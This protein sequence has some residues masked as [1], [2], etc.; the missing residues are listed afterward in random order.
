M[1][2][3]AQGVGVRLSPL[4]DEIPSF[5]AVHNILFPSPAPFWGAAKAPYPTNIWWTNLAF[6]SFPLVT[7]PYLQT[8]T[9][10]SLSLCVPT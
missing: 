9:N 7:Y 10:N 4:S 2:P 8:P 1:L 3:V 6:D 5:L